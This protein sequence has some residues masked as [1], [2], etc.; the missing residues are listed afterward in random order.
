[1]DQQAIFDWTRGNNFPRDYG[2]HTGVIENIDD[3]NKRWGAGVN[4]YSSVFGLRQIA[5]MEYDEFFYDIDGKTTEEAYPRYKEALDKLGDM[6][7]RKYCSGRGFWLHIDSNDIVRGRDAYKLIARKLASS[8]GIDKISDTSVIGDVRRVSR[9]PSSINS[10]TGMY[11]TRLSGD[12]SLDEIMW[13]VKNYVPYEAEVRRHNLKIEIEGVEPINERRELGGKWVGSYPS[14]IINAERFLKDLGELNH[15][16]RLHL[17]AFLIQIG[18]EEELWEYLKRANDFNE[19]I[20]KYQINYLRANNILPY[21][22]AN[23]SAE[24]CPFDVKQQCPFYPSINR[25]IIREEK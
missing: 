9:L 17:A 2:F 13:R 21:K 1:M 3:L 14:C 7:T 23:A 24:I 20:S 8:Y 18:R 19:G 25:F 22:C 16:A 11:V 4:Q 12:E 5:Y 10:K 6:V 15:P